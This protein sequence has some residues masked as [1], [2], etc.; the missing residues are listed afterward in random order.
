MIVEKTLKSTAPV[1]VYEPYFKVL[2]EFHGKSYIDRYKIFCQK[3][4]LERHYN[5]CCL[6]WASSDHS[7]G[8]VDDTISI[9]LFLYSFTGHLYGQIN[10]F[11]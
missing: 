8:D 11:K 1:R 6:I 9:K 10:E 4:I 2:Q 3:L 7:Y 5:S